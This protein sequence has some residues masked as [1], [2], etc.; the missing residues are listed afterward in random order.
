MSKPLA[1]LPQ[2]RKIHHMSSPMLV[3]TIRRLTIEAI[4]W[5]LLNNGEPAPCTPTLEAAEIEAKRRGI[6]ILHPEIHH[7]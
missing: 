6:T 3:A 5:R 4:K 7:D 1:A 2:A